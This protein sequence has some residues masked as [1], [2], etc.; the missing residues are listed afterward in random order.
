MRLPT[1]SVLGKYLLA[2]EASITAVT[3]EC[4]SSRSVKKRPR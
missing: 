1:G 4:S 3:G 2:K